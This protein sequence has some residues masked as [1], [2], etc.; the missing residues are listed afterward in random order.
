MGESIIEDEISQNLSQLDSI[1]TKNGN[2]TV[3][4]FY[5]HSELGY[6][7]LD[8]II[9][10]PENT[11]YKLFTPGFEWDEEIKNYWN[12]QVYS[13]QDMK[14]M[15]FMFKKILCHKKNGIMQ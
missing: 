6:T 9:Q 10:N 7:Y 13:I 3:G 8:K 11:F 4:D 5:C 14:W 1:E 12:G 15:K 2:Y